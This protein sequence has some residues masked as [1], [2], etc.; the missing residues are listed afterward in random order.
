[1]DLDE[2]AEFASQELLWFRNRLLEE[3]VAAL[4]QSCLVEGLDGLRAVEGRHGSAI[5]DYVEA[6]P[7]E[8]DPI[9]QLIPAGKERHLFL[10][11]ATDSVRSGAALLDA[12]ASKGLSA[13]YKPSKT[14]LLMQAAQVAQELAE[15]DSSPWPF[16]DY[17]DP[18]S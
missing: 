4:W 10:I 3:G 5:R 15:M 18:F 13:S 2:Y 8:R 1:M 9:L 7:A 12:A 14:F 11:A 6:P 17:A 16:D